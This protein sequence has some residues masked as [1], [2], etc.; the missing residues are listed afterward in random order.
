MIDLIPML[1][2]FAAGYACGWLLDYLARKQMYATMA[3]Q[4]KLI[5]ELREQLETHERAQAFWRAADTM[6]KRN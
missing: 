4:Q 1:I 3:A 6:A 2:P 5:D